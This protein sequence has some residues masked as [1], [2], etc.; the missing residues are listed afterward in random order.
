M[1]DETHHPTSLSIA[2]SKKG[3]SFQYE[4]HSLCFYPPVKAQPGEGF[5]S[6][7]TVTLEDPVHVFTQANA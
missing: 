7:N 6:N 3:G 1:G 4:I 5:G 2:V